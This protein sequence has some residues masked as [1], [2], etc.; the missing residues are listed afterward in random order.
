MNKKRPYLGFIGL[1]LIITSIIADWPV[2]LIVGAGLLVYA[3]F[4]G[5]VKLFG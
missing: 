3:L 5:H 4:A 1:V 2:T